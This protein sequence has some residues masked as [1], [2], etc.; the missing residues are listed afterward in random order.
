MEPKL[1]K[2]SSSLGKR[3]ASKV[4][5]LKKKRSKTEENEE[6]KDEF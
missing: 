5:L 4:P 6:E 3:E 2:Q 1:T